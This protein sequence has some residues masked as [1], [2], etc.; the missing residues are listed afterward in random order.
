MRNVRL[1][2]A[3]LGVDR[4]TVIEDIEF[5]EDGDGAELVVA[6]VRSRSGMSGRCGRC[7]RKAPWYDR[8]EDRGGGGAWTWA[9]SGCFGG[10]GA[11][12]ELPAHGPTVVMVP[13][14]RH[15]AGHTFAFDDTVAWLAVACSKTA[16]C[17]LMRIAW[18]TVGAVVARVWADTEKTVD[19]F[20]NLRRIGIDE[21][22]YKRHHK[23]LTVVVDHDSGHLIWA[24]PGRD[25]ATLRRFFDAL[26][27]DRAAQITHVSADAADWIADVVAERCPAA[28]RCADPFHVVAWATEAL[29]AER[30]RAWN[31]ARTLARTEAKWGRGRP[32]KNTAPRPGHERARRLKGARYA[33]WKNPED[34]SERQTAKLAWIAK[35]DPRLYRAYLLKEGLRHVFSVKGEEGKQALDRWISW[36][37]RCRIPVFVELAGRIVRHRQAIDAALD[38]GLSQGLIESTN[39]KIRVLTRVA[40]GFHNPA[41]LIALAMLAL[42]GHRPTLP[43]RG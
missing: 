22:A 13:W 38:H 41:A 18:R 23:Y 14:A 8:G 17:E 21:I 29:D 19:R 26:G 1:W 4:R 15:H 43:G 35:T 10:R 16:V 37:R 42:G 32:A 12:G 3:L 27:A 31:D 20:A 39:T 28:I 25:T 11:A 6:W 2:R 7:Q 24:A 30:R 9:R 36:A 34:L 5:A 33:L 40:F